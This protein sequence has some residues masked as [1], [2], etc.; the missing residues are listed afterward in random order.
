L[1]FA[2]ISSKLTFQI[3]GDITPPCGEPI[4]SFLV[5]WQLSSSKVDFWLFKKCEYHLVSLQ[6]IAIILYELCRGI[7]KVQQKMN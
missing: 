1:S 7:E 5:N 4:T 2:K 6:L 3:S